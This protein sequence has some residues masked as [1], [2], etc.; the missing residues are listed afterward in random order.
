MKRPECKVCGGAP[1]HELYWE[2]LCVTCFYLMSPEE[3]KA[4]GDALVS[5]FANPAIG[6]QELEE[7]LED[8]AGKTRSR[9]LDVVRSSKEGSRV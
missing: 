3:V 6:W 1:S 8:I 5:A 2:N 7:R 4:Y 9:I